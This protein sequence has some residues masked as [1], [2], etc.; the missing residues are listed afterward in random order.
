MEAKPKALVTGG[1]SGIGAEFARQLAAQ[2]YDVVVAGRRVEKLEGICAEIRERYGVNASYVRADLADPAQLLELEKWI[3]STPEL[4]VLINNA[5]YGTGIDFV[6]NQPDAMEDMIRVH[7][8]ATVRLAH[9][10]VKIM[11][12]A[13]KG[14]I[15]NVSSIAAFLVSNGD[16][17]YYC[18]KT[19]LNSFTESLHVSVKH[20]GIRV[21]ALCPGFTVSEFHSRLGMDTEA[22]HKQA[23]FMT[24]EAVVRKSLKALK[25]RRV[26]F[27][28]GFI[29]KLAVFALKILPRGLLYAAMSRRARKAEAAKNADGK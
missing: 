20:Y 5:G 11:K 2:G 24:A 15:V 26:I 25:R 9:A 6:D 12:K 3:A 28:P 23:Y 1:S 7:D 22:L 29:N 27:V 13:G 19:F 16:I 8:I 4:E 17:L 21:E 14:S 10:A 18:T